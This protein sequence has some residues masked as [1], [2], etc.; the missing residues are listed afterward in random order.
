MFIFSWWNLRATFVKQGEDDK[1]Q[2]LEESRT[3]MGRIQTGKCQE[4]L[5]TKSFHLAFIQHVNHFVRCGK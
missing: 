5:M 4:E 2:E 1:R 3:Q